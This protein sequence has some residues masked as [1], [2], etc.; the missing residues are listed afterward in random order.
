MILEI[1][2]ITDRMS[3]QT[4]SPKTR[5]VP[6]SRAQALLLGE[7]LHVTQPGGAGLDAA[8]HLVSTAS[9]R[10]R[11]EEQDQSSRSDP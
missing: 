10:L 5:C 4:V 1:I 11:H 6:W 7:G 3:S 9:L 2:L 8:P